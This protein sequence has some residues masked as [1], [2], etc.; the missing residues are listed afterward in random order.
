MREEL[1]L[2]RRH[3]DEATA[4]HLRGN[5]YGLEDFKA[6]LCRLHRVEVEEVGDVRDRRL[7]HLQCHFGLDTLSWARRGARVTGVDFSEHAIASARE[8]AQEVGLEKSSAFVCS[9]LYSLAERLDPMGGF[10]VVYTSYGVLNWLPELRPWGALIARYLKPGGFFYIVDAH[11]FARVFPLDEDMP[12]AGTFRPFFPYFHDPV[13]IRWPPGVDYAN[14]AVQHQIGNH[15]WQHSLS[16]ILGALAAA[17]L[18]IDALHEFPYC[19]WSVVAGCELVER[20][21]SSHGYYALPASQPQLPLM[22]SLRASRPKNGDCR[23]P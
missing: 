12:K 4:L 5:D 17:G 13:G 10:D 2:N 3:W 21:S 11:P 7:L 1:E 8:L 23:C 16:D 19:A 14:P 22:F 6:G 9:D 18:R 15:E 20:F